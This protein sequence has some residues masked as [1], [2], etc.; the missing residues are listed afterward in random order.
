MDESLTELRAQV[1]LSCR[2]LALTG[3]VREILGH[4]SARIPDTDEMF[5]RCRGVTEFGLAFTDAA[6][7]RRL[8]LDGTGE[9]LGPDHEPPHEL[10]I[11]G[12][13]LRARPEV[14]A[15]VHAHP[16]AVLLC[17]LAGIELR[18]VFGAYDPFAMALAWDK[19]PIY[20]RS[21]LINTS[22]LAAEVIDVMGQNDVCI[23]RGHGIAVTGR[24]VLEATLRAIRLEHL[25]QVC[26]QLAQHGPLQEISSDDKQAFAGLL[27]SLPTVLPQGDE[28]VWRSYVRLLDASGPT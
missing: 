24:T 4:V 27:A 10:P 20:P 18:P 12:E 14:G 23:L 8:H 15:V 17:G 6:A 28:W 11:H 13:I 22:A 5:I 26:W 1:A 21:I 25:A 9:G 7:I 3:V 19:I 2:I 16:T